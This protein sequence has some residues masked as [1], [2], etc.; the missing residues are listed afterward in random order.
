VGAFHGVKDFEGDFVGSSALVSRKKL[1]L[2]SKSA[3]TI[4]IFEFCNLGSLRSGK[5]CLQNPLCGSLDTLRLS[6]KDTQQNH[7]YYFI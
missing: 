7:V 2:L 1:A 5:I 6:H 3:L 4:K